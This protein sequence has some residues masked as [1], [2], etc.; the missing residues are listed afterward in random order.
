MLDVDS[1]PSTNQK[2]TAAAVLSTTT[3]VAGNFAF[4]AHVVAALVSAVWFVS[5]CV[6]VV[7]ECC[8][9]S[10]T[11]YRKSDPTVN[12]LMLVLIAYAVVK[13]VHMARR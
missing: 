13:L 5:R 3:F 9:H 4:I 12:L 7:V 2:A 6:E 10:V 1:T 11:H 8:A